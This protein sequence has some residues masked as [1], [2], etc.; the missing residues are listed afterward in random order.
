MATKVPKDNDYRRYTAKKKAALLIVLVLML[1]TALFALGTGSAGLSVKEVL[2]T[3]LGKGSQEAVQ[4]IFNLRLLRVAAAVVAGLGLAAAGCVM[5]AV[6]ENPLASSST[7][8]IAQGAAF[9]AAV[10]IVLFG[11]GTQSAG[12]GISILNPY[13]V[14]LC[15]FASSMFSTFVILALARFRKIP[16]EAMILCGMALSSLFSGAT[17]LIQYFADDVQVSAVVFWTFGDLGRISLNEIIMMAV[18][19]VLSLFYFL[20]N[21]WNYNALQSGED[22]AKGL[23][24][25]VERLRLWGMVISSLSAA[26]IVSFAGV[27]NFIGLIAPHIMRRFVGSDYRYLLPAS[28]L[29][30]ALLVLLSDLA[31]RLILAPV[32]LPIGALTSF[33]GAPL[34]LYLIFRRVKSG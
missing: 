10:A 25:N 20:F 21:L 3:L 8:G 24:V 30:G 6:L 13:L 33:L 32:V 19:V 34:F 11:A 4:L 23:G 9:G 12:S 17:A 5:Q 26:V 29:M 27:I 2:F 7:L 15:A 28:A 18:V 1:L 31:A 22:T 16:P 14:T